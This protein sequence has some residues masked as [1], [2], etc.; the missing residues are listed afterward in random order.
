MRGVERGVKPVGNDRL[1]KKRQ[2]IARNA[3]SSASDD[4]N[5]DSTDPTLR[6]TAG[7]PERAAC[8]VEKSMST[9]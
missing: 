9:R 2:L 8:V 6:V 4:G 5:H 1:S 3:A 7:L